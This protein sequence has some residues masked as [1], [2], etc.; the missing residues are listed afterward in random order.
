MGSLHILYLHIPLFQV[1]CNDR[2]QF[3]INVHDLKLESF[4]FW[5]K[6]F[7]V[8]IYSWFIKR[9]ADSLF[10]CLLFDVVIDNTG[11]FGKFREAFVNGDSHC[12]ATPVQA[13][14]F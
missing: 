9:T 8:N 10:L 6:T 4:Y 2:N 5:H 13:F 12:L 1:E 3:F 11:A 7:I 14:S